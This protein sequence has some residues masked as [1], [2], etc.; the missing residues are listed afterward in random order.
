MPPLYPA[1]GL[2]SLPPANPAFSFVFA[3]YPPDPRS[4]SALP[5]GKGETKVISCKGLRP[6]HPLH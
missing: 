3:P 6:L 1:G 2:P 4:Q 5:G